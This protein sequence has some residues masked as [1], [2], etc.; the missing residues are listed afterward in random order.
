MESSAQNPLRINAKKLLSHAKE[1]KAKGS[2][3]DLLVADIHADNGLELFLKD[4]A[5]FY[6]IRGAK[7]MQV[8]ELIDRLKFKIPELRDARRCADLNL[9]H[10]F[11]DFSY[12]M[13]NSPD[14]AVLGWCI[15]CVDKFMQDVERTEGLKIVVKK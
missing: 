13:G 12:H 6:N 7:T 5:I 2:S 14:L 11:R 1:H 15:D 10:N 9:V 3:F 8:P 4:F